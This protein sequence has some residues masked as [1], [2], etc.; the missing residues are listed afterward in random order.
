MNEKVIPI[1]YACDDNFAKYMIVSISS[2]I[3]NADPERQYQIHVLH[4]NISEEMQAATKR[5][6]REGFDIDFVNVNPY[7]EKIQDKLPLRHYYT[8]TTYF[9]LFIAEMFPEYDK[10]IYIDSDTVVLGDISRLYDADLGDN[11]VGGCHEQAMV[12]VDV[13]G[14]Y[15]E[16]VVGVSRH[17]FFNAGMLLI[18]CDMW[19]KAKLLDRF[20][21]LLGEYNFVVTQDEDYL[22]LI[23]K[24]HVCWL[25]QRWNTEVTEGFK[26]PYDINDAYILHYIMVNKPWHY[27]DCGGADIFWACAKDTEMYEAIKAEL[28]AYTDEERE[29]DRLSAENLYQMAIDETASENNYQRILNKTV[30]SA[31]RVAV[32]EKMRDY[33]ER[34]IFDLDLE[35]DPPTKEL[36]PDQIDYFRRSAYDKIK[37]EVA[38]KMAKGFLEKIQREGQMIIREVRGLE[39]M[40]NLKS[41]AVITCNHFN[42]FDTFAMHEAYLR[43]GVKG[44]T[45]YRV[46][47]EG[48]YTSFGGFYGYLMRNFYTLPLSSNRHTINKFSVAVDSLLRDGHFV[49]IYPEQ[50]LW[51]NYRKPK[52]LKSGAYSIALKSEVPILPCFITMKDSRT[53]GEDGYPIQEYTVN[54]GEPIYPDSSLSRK[55]SIEKMMEENARVWREIYERDYDM[56]LEYTTKVKQAL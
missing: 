9:R 19:K 53:L 35:D 24:D 20:L 51:W 18:N 7:L 31:D 49:L 29:R 2:L 44:K 12:Q 6:E 50:S 47:R 26:Y 22:N 30:R 39:N 32:I 15:A 48:N 34:G 56:P 16:E 37:T 40:A 14:T 54:I 1:F 33:E 4:T 42:P 8:K 25:D 21:T 28:E 10:A 36:L 55:E 38:Y 27:H 13:Y 3:N 43:S 52:P 41:G 45:L 17:N 11:L 46:I 23:C 5:L